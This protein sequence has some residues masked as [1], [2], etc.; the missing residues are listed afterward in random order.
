MLNLKLLKMENHIPKEYLNC[1]LTLIVFCYALAALAGYLSTLDVIVNSRYALSKED[2]V[3]NETTE[4]LNI[5]RAF[6]LM[7]GLGVL[8]NITYIW[9]S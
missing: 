7:L 8:C 5:R 6:L 9:L 2:F 4:D 1:L 3:E